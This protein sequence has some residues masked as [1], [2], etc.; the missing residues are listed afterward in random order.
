M[1]NRIR[2]WH[3]VFRYNY[4]QRNSAFM[5][6]VI[7]AIFPDNSLNYVCKKTGEKLTQFCTQYLF[8]FCFFFWTFLSFSR[9]Q[10][11]NTFLHILQGSTQIFAIVFLRFPWLLAG[12]S[13]SM[14]YLPTLSHLNYSVI[15]CLYVYRQEFSGTRE[16]Y[17]NLHFPYGDIS[18]EIICNKLTL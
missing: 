8:Y 5:V 4:L 18:I 3:G 11:S 12:T 13:F 14:L 7:R 6:G 16:P 10:S 2:H 17:L 9:V 15:S 1:W